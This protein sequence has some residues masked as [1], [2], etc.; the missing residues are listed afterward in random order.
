MKL[1]IYR[2]A[3]TRVPA[4]AINTLF[5]LIAEEEADPAW[6]A[7]INLVFTHDRR[8]RKLNAEYR[9]KDRPTDVLSFNV[10][11]PALAGKVFGE[12]YISSETALRQAQEYGFSLAQ[13]YLRLTC[14]G[15]LH[16]FGYDH[17]R[18]ADKRKMTG[19]ELKF[20]SQIDRRLG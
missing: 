2:E 15:L 9:S 8:L 20:L 1:H 6:K 19:K 17:I 3:K 11:D 5:S 12:V 16:L 4:K 7:D 13:E 14:H 10:D 18:S